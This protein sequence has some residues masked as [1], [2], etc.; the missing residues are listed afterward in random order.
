MIAQ[1]GSGA[2]QSY[3]KGMQTLA[4]TTEG[5][6]D[7]FYNRMARAKSQVD[8][9]LADFEHEVAPISRGEITHGGKLMGDICK[10]GRPNMATRRPHPN[11]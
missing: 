10:V 3:I 4:A 1:A 8:Q 6:Q 11:A 9:S 2:V 7:T 5:K